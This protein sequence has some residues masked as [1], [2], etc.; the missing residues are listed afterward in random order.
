MAQIRFKG[1]VHDGKFIPPPKRA[2]AKHLESDLQ[3][4][5]V[6]WFRAHYPDLMLFSIPNGGA[7][8]KTTATFLKMEGVVAGVADLCLLFPNNGYHALFIEMKSHKGVQR[9]T[10]KAFQL[11]CMRYGYKYLICKDFEDF[12][13]QIRIYLTPIIK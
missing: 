8:D 4:R 3:I 12:K 9:D 10:Q 6:S 1:K 11:Y 13:N 5:C 2:K 7:R